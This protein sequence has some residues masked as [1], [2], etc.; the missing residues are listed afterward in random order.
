MAECP[1]YPAGVEP[2]SDRQETKQVMRQAIRE[3]RRVLPD[4]PTRSIALWLRVTELPRVRAAQHVLAYNSLKGEPVSAPFVEWCRESGKRV[5]FPEDTPLPDATDYDLVIVPGV[6]FTEGGDRLGRGGGWYDRLL[7]Q[8]RSDCAT[9]GVAF[10]IQLLP[11]LPVE[12]HDRPVGVVVTETHT[13]G[14][15]SGV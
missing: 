1:V 15:T 14:V 3:L 12:P 10:D 5:S 4:Q 13:Y 6:A 2:A 9:V 8:L 11:E 7:P